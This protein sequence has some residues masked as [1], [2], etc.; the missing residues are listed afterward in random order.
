MEE[1]QC[2]ILMATTD[3]VQESVH[4]F[5]SFTQNLLHKTSKSAVTIMPTFKELCFLSMGEKSGKSC[6][7]QGSICKAAIKIIFLVPSTML[8]WKVK[9]L[10]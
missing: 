4:T 5:F 10:L 9:I 3:K 7:S 2:T 8:I 6:K 1:R